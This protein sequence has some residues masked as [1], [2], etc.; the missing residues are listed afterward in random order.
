MKQIVTQ[1]LS[2]TLPPDP[3][4]NEFVGEVQNTITNSGQS[5]TTG[6]TNQ[7]QKAIADNVGGITFYVETGAANAYV[8]NVTGSFSTASAYRNG[9]LVRFRA[10]NA[11]TGASTINVSSLGVKSIKLADGST[12]P[13]AGDISTTEDTYLRYDGT[14]F[15][16]LN[17]QLPKLTLTGTTA[18]TPRANTLYKDNICKA[19]INFNGTGTIAIND[20]FNVT[21][22]IDNTTGDYTVTWD[23]D[24]ADINYVPVLG[25]GGTVTATHIKLY[26]TA[27]LAV[28][29][30][31]VQTLSNAHTS[32]D[33]AIIAIAA[34]GNQT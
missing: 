10:V 27:P 30:T 19:W 9:M 2:T 12:D 8:C 29:T 24:F 4:F 16:L 6:T 25:N 11:N 14:N 26:D 31:R 7:L 34:Y 33:C 22:I 23:R 1:S 28:G 18:T 21:G 3:E 15:L 17:I 20:S 5:L 32:I 13:E